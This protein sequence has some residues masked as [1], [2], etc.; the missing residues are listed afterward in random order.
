MSVDVLVTR[1]VLSDGGRIPAAFCG[2]MDGIFNKAFENHSK[3]SSCI[4][5]S[6][7][8]EYLKY[9]ILFLVHFNM[10][11]LHFISTVL[12]I[13]DGNIQLTFYF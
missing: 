13:Y 6:H 1:I 10:Y 2:N 9:N 11:N 12:L 5:R 3:W 4:P 7:A 8:T